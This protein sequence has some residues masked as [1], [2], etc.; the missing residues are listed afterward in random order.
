MSEEKLKTIQGTLERITFHNEENGFTV[1]RLQQQD[2][3]GELTTIVG[4]L[5]G[6]PVGSTLSLF[7]AY[8]SKTRGTAGS[9]RSN[10]MP[11]SGPT[12]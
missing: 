12:P 1:A 4:H 9:S 3:T 11:W 6:V 10:N 5:S 8:G 7:P 2:K